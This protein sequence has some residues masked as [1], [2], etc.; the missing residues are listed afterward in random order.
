MSHKKSKHNMKLNP[1]YHSI[2]IK[3]ISSLIFA[4]LFISILV[5]AEG[6]WPNKVL[7]DS[8]YYVKMY[9]LMGLK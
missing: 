5:I 2:V 1:K 6:V 8:M 3:A 9:L 7:K 4:L